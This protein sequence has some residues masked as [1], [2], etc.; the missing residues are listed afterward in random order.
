MP[1]RKEISYSV[2]QTVKNFP[3]AAALAMHA[4]FDGAVALGVSREFTQ[5]WRFGA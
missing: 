1:V 5:E 2:L 3:S 4:G